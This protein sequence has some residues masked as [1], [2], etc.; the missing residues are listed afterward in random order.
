MF[1]KDERGNSGW[2]VAARAL[3]V[4]GAGGTMALNLDPQ[5]DSLPDHGHFCVYKDLKR[6]R[7][8]QGWDIHAIA[9]MQD[10]V[11]FARAF[12]R[13]HYAAGDTRGKA[14]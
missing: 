7:S 4:G 5:W 6:A 12:S 3:A 1:E 13:R 11:A 10:L 8:E 14:R 2:D 9:D